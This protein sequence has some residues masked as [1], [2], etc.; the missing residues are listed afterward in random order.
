MRI[1]DHFIVQY[2]GGGTA[3]VVDNRTMQEAKVELTDQYAVGKHLEDIQ[4]AQRTSST[5]VYED[6]DGGEMHLPADV[7]APLA[8]ALGYFWHTAVGEMFDHG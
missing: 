3:V 7:A 2:I 5:I 1:S 8:F 6:I 4:Q